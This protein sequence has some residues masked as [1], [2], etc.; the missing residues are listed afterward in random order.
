MK[1]TPSVRPYWYV[2]AKWICGILLALAL[3]IAL[4]FLT[5]AKLTDQD[6][7]PKIA[8]LV[9]GTTFIRGDT[10]DTPDNRQALAEHGGVIQPFANIPSVKI[11][12]DDLK[13]T[14][15][16]LSLKVFKP[17][18]ESIYNDGIEG[19]ADK[20]GAT[21]EQKAKFKKDASLFTIFTK[22]AHQKLQG[23]FILFAI[24]SLLLALGV[25][26]FSAGWGRLSNLG[27]LL[28]LISVPGTLVA[29]MLNHPPKDEYG[30]FGTFSPELTSQLGQ[31][32]AAA[33]T[34]VTLLGL[35]LLVAALFGRVYSSLSKPKGK[36]SK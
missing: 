24:V 21:A 15:G 11:T 1:L 3:T 14:P 35:A 8:A 26:Y 31:A 19:A 33:Y 13:L 18:T 34:K 2:D 30:G 25:V 36:S 10:V 12:A 5:L 7:G 32:A 27:F 9:I 23:I 4:T 6:Q 29:L 16:Q 28:L 17:L 20:F 22:T